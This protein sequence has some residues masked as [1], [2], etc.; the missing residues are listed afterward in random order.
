MHVISPGGLVKMQIAVP[1]PI[2]SDSVSLGLSLRICIS[3]ELPDA[4]DAA[5]LGTTL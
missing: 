3:D 2:V 5:G 4:A 1:S